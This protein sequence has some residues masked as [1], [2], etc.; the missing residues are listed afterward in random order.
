[1]VNYSD[2]ET[3]IL[4]WIKDR[5]SDGVLFIAVRRPCLRPQG[6]IAGLRSGGRP[7]VGTSGAP[8][9]DLVSEGALALIRR[10]L[11]GRHDHSWPMNDAPPD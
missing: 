2:E 4:D 8:P 9:R 5:H 10:P 11:I 6:Q 3:E 7:E 1:M